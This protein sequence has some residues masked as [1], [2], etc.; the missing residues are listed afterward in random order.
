DKIFV[1]GY[2]P[3]IYLYADRS[4]ASR[5][6]YCS[7]QTGLIPWTNEAPGIDT[8][9]AIVPGSM[10]TLLRELGK[11]RPVFVVDCSAGP[12]RRFSKYPLKDFPALEEF[13]KTNYVELDPATFVLRGFRV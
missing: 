13:L 2:N 8:N 5:F 1:W 4:P 12:H 3:D 10:D 11:D 9:Y 6:L 7:F